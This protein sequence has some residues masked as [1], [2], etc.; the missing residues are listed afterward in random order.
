MNSKLNYELFKN[1]FESLDKDTFMK[2]IE[3][4]IPK[5]EITFK[6]D[7]SPFF[8]TADLQCKYTLYINIRYSIE[9][10]YTHLEYILYF[11]Y[12]TDDYFILAL[13]K[14]DFI[15]INEILQFE[16]SDQVNEE[17]YGSSIKFELLLMDYIDDIQKAINEFNND[18]KDEYFIYIH[19]NQIRMKIELE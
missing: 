6:F 19:E 13:D 12:K 15:K 18:H 5:T 1:A 17:I 2:V 7:K 3:N 8:E 4:F 11:D 16:F 14:E 10:T 9:H